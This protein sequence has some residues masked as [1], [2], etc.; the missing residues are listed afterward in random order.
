MKFTKTIIKNLKLLMRA[1]SSAFIVIFGPLI[2]ILLVGLAL[3]K[4]STYALSV[5]Y[6]TSDEN[7]PLTESFIQEL[8]GNNYLIIPYDSSESCIESIKKSE[9]HTC[10]IFPANF[11]IGNEA[12]NKLEF[13]VDYSRTNLVY[14]IIDDVSKNLELKTSELSKDLT[15]T[16]LTKIDTTKTSVDKDILSIITIKSAID[17]V[18]S[19]VGATQ[20]KTEDFDF[21]MDDISISK[22]KSGEKDLFTNAGSLKNL[23]FDAT[24]E[25]IDIATG[26]ETA[27]FQEIEEDLTDTYN[28]TVV[29]HS[30]FD[31]VADNITNILEAKV[32]EVEDQ[33]KEVS[34]N[35]GAITKSLDEVKTSTNTVKSSLE[36]TL[37]NL[38]NIDISSA[39]SI[40][41][42][43]KTEIKPIVAESN[44]LIFMFPFLLVLV[45]MFIGIMLSS[46]LLI[47]EKNSKAAFRNFTTPT[48]DRFF[49]V[50]TFVT[51]FIVLFLQIF[52]ILLLTQYFL[53]I[54]IFANFIVTSLVLLITIAMFIFVGMIIGYLSRTQESSTMLSITI[55][56]VFL[57]VSNLILPIETMSGFMKS[58]TRFNPYVV[59]S[60]LLRKAMLFKVQFTEILNDLLF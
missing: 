51:S 2:I 57:L 17:T 4:P 5:G 34:A 47:M 39:E 30:I 27:I 9:S 22:L 8:R 48:S 24:G 6:Y 28:T 32:E 55:G 42:P 1:K 26:N 54:D 3:N 43:I 11:E 60:E 59:S 29:I 25:G 19:T 50:T 12:A 15:Q 13:Y 49:V 10:I 20:D 37:E 45:I 40:V 53:K 31:D 23:G 38:E 33:K 46:A 35:L 52:I 21:S 16:L 41:S 7:N 56:S 18:I 58:L 44:Q 36:S 14:Q